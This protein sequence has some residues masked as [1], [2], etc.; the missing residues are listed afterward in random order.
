MLHCIKQF[1]GDI[2][3][4]LGGESLVVDGFIVAQHMKENCRELYDIL[5]DTPVE[6]YDIGEDYTKFHKVHHSPSFV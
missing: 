2:D 4:K 3:A 6:F 5:C 1:Y